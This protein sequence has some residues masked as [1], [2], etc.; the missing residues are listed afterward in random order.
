MTTSAHTQPLT[1]PITTPDDLAA[2]W[3]S[4][5]KAGACDRRTL[6]MVVLDDSGRPRPVI[7]P[8]DDVPSAASA[9]DLDGLAT[10]VAGLA[11]YGTVIA[12]LSRPGSQALLEGDHGWARALA[13]L[14]PRWPLQLAT[15]DGNGGFT[16]RPVMC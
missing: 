1:T 3:A 6:W 16:V 13:P 9:S 7:V 12:L 14:A 10:M 11:G 4:L 2:F 5:L 8:V 15:V